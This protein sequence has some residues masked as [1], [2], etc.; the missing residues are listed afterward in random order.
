M[1]Q[2]A[3][4]SICEIKKNKEDYLNLLLIADPSVDMIWHYLDRGDLYVMLLGRN[5]CMCNRCGFRQRDGFVESH[6]IKNFFIDNYP[7][8][9]FEDNGE[10]CI[11]MIYLRYT[12]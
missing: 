5:A 2:Q 1:K 8:P 9:I 3:D 11:D 7:E 10:Q 12:R 4:V 6:I